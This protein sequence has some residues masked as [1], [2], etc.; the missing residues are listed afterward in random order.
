M[1]NI[2][3]PT[4]LSAGLIQSN[5]LFRMSGIKLKE[6]RRFLS[7]RSLAKADPYRRERVG[8][9]LGWLG[10][11]NLSNGE[12]DVHRNDRDYTLRQHRDILQP[13]KAPL[14]SWLRQS[15]QL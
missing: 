14:S 12:T 6:G 1:L 9:P 7:G 11:L 4:L 8:V 10:I 15:D 13:I 3:T 2:D 5:Q